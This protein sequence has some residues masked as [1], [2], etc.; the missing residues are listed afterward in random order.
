MAVE[1][2]EDDLEAGKMPLLEH[3]VELR[4][5]LIYSAVA[6]LIFL[7]PCYYFSQHIFDFLAHPLY[8]LLG[9]GRR[10]I[11]TDLTEAFFTHLRIAIWGA[12]CLASPIIMSQIWLFV[13]PG[14]YKQ[15]RRAFYP[16]M[17]ATPVLFLMGAALV[18]YL[19][20]PMAW[21]FFISF[22]SAGSGGSDQLPIQL[23]QK[24]SEYLT[25]VMHF[26][27][28]FGLAFQLPVALTL[29]ARVGLLTSDGLKAKRRYAIVGAFVAAAVLTPPD[30]LSQI[31]LAV[32]L[33]LLYEVSIIS[34]RMVEK[35]KAKEDAENEAETSGS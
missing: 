2:S 20:F 27:L 35:S 12:F 34:C 23:E 7:G 13:A 28:A 29:M 5:R 6:L 16:Y 33:M 9:P 8:E 4:N 22:E 24:I 25:L 14:L 1:K 18:Y 30:V 31:S 11:F 3:L 26:I 15:E 19:I 32:P 21:K 17:F 10:M